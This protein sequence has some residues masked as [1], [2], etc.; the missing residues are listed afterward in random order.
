[1]KQDKNLGPRLCS[2]IPF[3]QSGEIVA[4]IG[5][6]HAYLPIL[7]VREGIARHAVACDI[8]TG[9]IERAREHIRAAGME[10]KIDTLQTDGLHGVER[11]EPTAILI[12]GMGGELIVKILSE[13][14]WVKTG[15]IRLILQPMSHAEILRAWLR[16]NG[17]AITGETVTK[18]KHFYQT[19]CATYQGVGEDYT[20]AELAVGKVNL[21]TDPALYRALIAQRIRT[22]EKVCREKQKSGSANVSGEVGLIESL[23]AILQ[24]EKEKNK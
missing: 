1:M 23:R 9:P 14:A 20:A 18:E 4:D 24:S 19:L 3:L 16:D 17:F 2:A 7:L 13:T 15:R 5:T 12:F 22:L 8:G 10:E 6:D 11:W 21:Q